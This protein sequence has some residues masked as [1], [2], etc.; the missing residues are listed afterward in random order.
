MAFRPLLM[1]K[2]ML[3]GHRAPLTRTP[4]A[5]GLEYE[6]VGFTTSDGVD[7]KGWFIPA[8]ASAPAILWVHGWMWNRLG[9]VAGQ[10]VVPDRDVDFL[11]AIKALHD[12]GYH[13]LTYDWRRHGESDDGR[14]PL[15][16]GPVEA[17][18]FVAA[19]GYLRDRP[20]VSEIG[21]VGMSAGANVALYGVGAAEPITALLAVQPTKLDAFNTRFAR[22]ELGRFGP[23]LIKP[24]DL[25]YRLMRAPLPSAHDP[26]V[27]A[28]RLNGT[29]VRYVQGT[30]DQWGTMEVVESF[31]A[32]T[33]R[34]D[35][36][37]IAYPSQ[38]R[39][40]GY[41]Y[42]TKETGDIVAFFRA[43]FAHSPA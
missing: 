19:A 18:D 25:L 31:A 30:G 1:T 9:N 11:P 14:G 23:L 5:A 36:P 34:L 4:A 38:E 26:A 27:P 7:L 28:A 10:T 13:V 16:Y 32:A 43:S 21:V 22:T 40:S 39:Y 33:P 6:D 17:R 8:G 41:Q 12:A 20:D 24:V 42:I 2:L 29:V 35:G 37:V 3:R 15:T